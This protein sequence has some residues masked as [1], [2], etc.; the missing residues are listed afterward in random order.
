MPVLPSHPRVRPHRERTYVRARQATSRPAAEEPG[1]AAHHASIR[2]GAALSAPWHGRISPLPERP[3]GIPLAL[4]AVRRRGRDPSSPEGQAH[5]CRG[6]WRPMR[7]LRLRPVS[8]QLALSPRG[9]GDQVIRDQPERGEV[10]FRFPIGGS[11]V[12][13]RLCQLSWRNRDGDDRVPAGGLEVPR[14]LTDAPDAALR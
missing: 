10:A 2:S 6:K 12:R 7:G 8:C 3:A 1:S 9:P 11:E 13:T 5:A 4:Q 14:G